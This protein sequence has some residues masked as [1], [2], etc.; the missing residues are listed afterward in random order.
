MKTEKGLIQ[1]AIKIT[2]EQHR[3]LK[4]HP[5]IN[6]SRWIRD[7]LDQQ[8]RRAGFW[9]QGKGVSALVL[10]AGLDSQM[11]PFNRSIPKALLEVRGKSIFQRQ[12]EVLENLGV[13]RIGVVRGYQK[14]KFLFPGIYYYDNPEY[15]SRGIL[16][17]L[18][19]GMDFLMDSTLI[20]Y[21]DILFRRSVLDRLLQT[22]G[23]LIL[24]IDP[25]IPS[26]TRQGKGR[27]VE[28]VS[29]QHKTAKQ[30]LP[31]IERLSRNLP[32]S[33]QDGEFVGVVLVREGAIEKVKTL[34]AELDADPRNVRSDLLALFQAW[35]DGGERL[36]GMVVSSED[37]MDV[38]TFEDYRDAWSR[39][40]S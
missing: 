16:H 18:T 20:L 12:R 30:A 24:A 8:I 34:L 15:A 2:R 40:E 26:R 25:A 37:W 31:L 23:D 21:A 3:W 17:S 13:N 14:Q 36:Y 28:A 33:R 19:M 1:K 27:V 35:I 32:R 22:K 11:L 29:L 6:F 5:E 9:R 39:F 10:A 7:N 4:A 38:D